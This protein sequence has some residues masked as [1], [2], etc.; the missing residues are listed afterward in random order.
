[1]KPKPEISSNNTKRN[2]PLT[3]Y[4][5]HPTAEAETRSAAGKPT[6]NLR[7][8]HKLS[9]GFGPETSR[10][11]VTELFLFAL[12]TANSAWAVISMAIAVTRLVRNY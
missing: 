5:F 6:R 9:S 7:P 4:N 8:L 10:Q 11:Y 1:M 12:I 3:D 2:F